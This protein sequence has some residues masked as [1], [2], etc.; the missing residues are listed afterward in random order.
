MVST[1]PKNQGS[2]RLGG[3]P[4]GVEGEGEEGEDGV[5]RARRATPSVRDRRRSDRN[6]AIDSFPVKVHSRL[7]SW[8]VTETWIR[9]PPFDGSG[10]ERTRSRER[11]KGGGIGRNR[12]GPAP[13]DVR[14]RSR[15]A[16]G[17]E[18]RTEAPAE[19]PLERSRRRSRN[20]IGRAPGSGSDVGRLCPT[21]SMLLLPP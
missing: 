5:S 21:G 19:A 18:A 10:E 13:S 7:S 6:W 4:P 14:A 8:R 12:R 15:M 3:M 2:G 1:F 16:G 9:G 20:S 11:A 17:N